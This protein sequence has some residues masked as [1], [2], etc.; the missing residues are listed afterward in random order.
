MARRLPGAVEIQAAHLEAVSH[1]DDTVEDG[2]MALVAHAE[3]PLP[4]EIRRQLESDTLRLR[5]EVPVARQLVHGRRPAN[6]Y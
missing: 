5:L 2:P 1:V 3:R 6:G 4:T